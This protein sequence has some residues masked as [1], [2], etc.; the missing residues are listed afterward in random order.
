MPGFRKLAEDVYVFLPPPLV[1]YSSAGV[2]IGERD[3]IVVDSLTN[4]ALKAL[5]GDGVPLDFKRMII[6]AI[7]PARR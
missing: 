4:A 7:W 3:V 6:L 2:I 5:A 1:C